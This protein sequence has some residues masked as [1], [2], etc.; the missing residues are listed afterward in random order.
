MN[1]FFWNETHQWVF[2][3]NILIFIINPNTAEFLKWNNPL[4]YLELFIIILDIYQDENLDVGQPIVWSLVRLHGCL[5]KTLPVYPSHKQYIVMHSTICFNNKSSTDF[6]FFIIT[7]I[8][9]KTLL[10]KHLRDHLR[11]MSSLIILSSYNLCVDF[12]RF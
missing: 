4:P 8:H 11:P 7:Y 5:F 12:Y 1:I 2:Y 3:W 10:Q 6:Y 9:H